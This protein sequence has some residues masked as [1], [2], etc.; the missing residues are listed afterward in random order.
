MNKNF[1]SV[2]L[3][4]TFAFFYGQNIA[5]AEISSLSGSK[6]SCNLNSNNVEKAKSNVCNGSFCDW[7]MDEQGTNFGKCG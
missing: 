1:F 6:P 2:I 7:T 5:V 4:M 3:V